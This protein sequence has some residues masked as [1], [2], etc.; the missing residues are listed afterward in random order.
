MVGS[1]HCHHQ[2]RIQKSR[3]G[4]GGCNCRCRRYL[5]MSKARSC[6][7][8]MLPL[9]LL[10]SRAPFPA[11]WDV[12]CAPIWMIWLNL[13]VPLF[14]DFKHLNHCILTLT[15]PKG[16]L[17]AYFEYFL[18]RF[19]SSGDSKRGGGVRRLRPMLDTPLITIT[20]YDLRSF[21]C[22]KQWYKHTKCFPSLIWAHRNYTFT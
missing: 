11:I 22:L 1:S 7:G 18:Y 9:K 12:F 2:W 13:L 4:G 15:Q 17:W 21:W 16:N 3:Y 8:G 20:R 10:K 6:Q 5:C 19:F 14:Q